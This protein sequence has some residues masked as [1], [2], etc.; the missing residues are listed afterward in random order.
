MKNSLKARNGSL[1]TN[2]NSKHERRKIAVKCPAVGKNAVI[3][4]DSL[5]V[6]KCIPGSSIDAIVTDPPY[7]IG[8][9]SSWDSFSS[10]AEY[11]S[12]TK[13]WA[14]EALRVIKPG[15]YMLAF[16]AP[17]LQHRAAMGIESAGFSV[18]DS[19]DWIYAT[20]FSKSRD[21]GVIMDKQSCRDRL[22]R[23]LGRKP[24]RDESLKGWQDC[25]RVVGRKPGNRKLETGTYGM[26][27]NINGDYKQRG[28]VPVDLDII[29]PSSPDGRKWSGWGMSLKPAH[30]A[31]ILA[32]K[33]M[34]G[35]FVGNAKKWETGPINISGAL[36][37]Y[38][39]EKD[40]E[41]S[42][43]GLQRFAP[44]RGKTFAAAR[45][46][47]STDTSTLKGNLDSSHGGRV[48][49]NIILSDPLLGDYDKYFLV[50]KAK[51]G[52]KTHGGKIANDHQTVK[53][54]NLMVHLVKLVTRE[55]GTV[56]DPF[57]G[58]GTTLVAAK[59]S[60]RNFIGIDID[61]KSVGT[62]E[63]RIGA[64]CG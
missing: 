9:P 6:M 10:N 7:N 22:E 13:K 42:T 46:G 28:R 15:G 63:A 5:D 14:T 40:L 54:I 37:P 55:G 8:V 2:G 25:K 18:K 27:G 62:A 36:I 39:G 57:A 60:G 47:A 41:R 24:S 12:W 11:Q 21:V 58:S 64:G 26:H 23:K 51:K 4:G 53:P 61:A 19:L 38:A 44:A 20:G 49:S 56:L 45:A 59:C 32:Q 34:E 50:P 17:R 33:P 30:E 1:K 29:E 16:A 35:G 43:K 52:E 3:H 48:P 31:V